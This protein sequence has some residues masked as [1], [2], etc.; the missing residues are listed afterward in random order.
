MCVAYANA[1]HTDKI[2]EKW[3][4]V[5]GL[6]QL[7][8]AWQE[9]PV[10]RYDLDHWIVCLHLGVPLR[11]GAG[12]LEGM[13]KGRLQVTDNCV[14]FYIRDY[15]ISRDGSAGTSG[16]IFIACLALSK[17]ASS[18]SHNLSTSISI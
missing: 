11:R 1:E 10:Q 14:K 2:K 16:F 13:N 3:L 12:C 15:N 18:F 5:L 17:L 6:G 8:A 4:G 9:R 7:F